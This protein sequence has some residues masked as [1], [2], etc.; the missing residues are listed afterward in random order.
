VDELVMSQRASL[1][2]AAALLVT[3]VATFFTYVVLELM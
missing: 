3:A 2:T 1:A